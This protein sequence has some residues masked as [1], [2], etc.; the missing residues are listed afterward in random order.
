LPRSFLALG[1]SYTIG[2]GVAAEDRWPERLAALLGARGVVLSPPRVIARTGWT[3]ADLA[4]ALAAERPTGPFDLVSLMIGVNDQFRGEELAEYERR[5]GALLAEAVALAGGEPRRVLVLS[6][7]DYGVTPFARGLRLDARA[8]AAEVDR[9][10]DAARAAAR[11]TGARWVDVTPASR[12][13]AADAELLAR[14]GLHPSEKL[15][16]EWAALVLPAALAAL[17]D[18]PPAR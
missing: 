12:R 15:H 10:N 6:I 11:N 4:R 5:F 16:A 9:F 3:T 18:E 1:D 2:Q 8:V 14:D 13:A 7:P 17:S